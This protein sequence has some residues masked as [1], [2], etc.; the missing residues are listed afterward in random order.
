[1][2]TGNFPR[3]LTTALEAQEQGLSQKGFA[4]D[5]SEYETYEGIMPDRDGGVNA[6]ITG[7]ARLR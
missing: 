3:L 2:H 6:W 7:D 5:L 4:L 1:M